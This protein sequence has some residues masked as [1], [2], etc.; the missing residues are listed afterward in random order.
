ME[1]MIILILILLAIIL[2]IKIFRP[3]FILLAGLATFFSPVI[4]PYITQINGN[5]VT[6][7]TLDPLFQWALGLILITTTIILFLDSTDGGK[8]HDSD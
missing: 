3:T 5:T 1:L 8:T 4:L 7:T 2:P 6:Y